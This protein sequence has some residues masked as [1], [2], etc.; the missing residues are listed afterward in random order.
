MI[1]CFFFRKVEDDIYP[2]KICEGGFGDAY[3][4]FFSGNSQAY[5]FMSFTELFLGFLPTSP[6][7]SSSFPS[8]S[9]QWALL[10][11]LL[12]L[13]LKFNWKFTT[14]VVQD[15]VDSVLLV[16][17][18]FPGFYSYDAVHINKAVSLFQLQSILLVLKL[19]GH[20]LYMYL[21]LFCSLLY[22]AYLQPSLEFCPTWMTHFIFC[23]VFIFFLIDL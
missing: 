5:T 1:L 6:K 7:L 15:Y 11:N 17:L 13:Y 9:S 16:I 23:A 14:C 10:W 21:K 19:T 22:T 4:F 3:F 12:T 18:S 8:F 2:S 20:Q